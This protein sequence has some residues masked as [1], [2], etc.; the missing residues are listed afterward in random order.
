MKMNIKRKLLEEYVK[1]VDE[2]KRQ[3]KKFKVSISLIAIIMFL[4]LFL[5]LFHFLKG[6]TVS[7]YNKYLEQVILIQN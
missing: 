5:L 3:N 2:T 1:F 6:I 4:V 7:S